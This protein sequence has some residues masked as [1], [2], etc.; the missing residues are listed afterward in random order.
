MR[1]IEIKARIRS[2]QSIIDVLSTQNIIVTELITQHD[3][4][5]GQVGVDDTSDNTAAWLRI[6]SE[7]KQG[8]TKHIFTL[9]R[10]ITNQMDSIE[11]ETEIADPREL[12]A[13]IHQLDFSL[14]SD[15]T[16]T[17][18]KAHMGD[19]EICI[20]SVD[21][22]GS[23]VE[24]EKLTDETADYDAVV[25]ELWQVLKRLGVQSDDEVTDGY[26]VLMN[27]KLAAVQA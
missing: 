13:I 15:L 17:R 25:A 2:V 14:Y 12:K 27:K 5:Y 24:V 6:R 8:S 4:V 22:L 9:K 18:Q 11:H 10:S 19:I 1:E 23:F 3:R 21:G 16:K 7:T 20:D 26:D